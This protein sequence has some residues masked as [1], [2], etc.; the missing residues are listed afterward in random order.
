MKIKDAAEAFLSRRR[1]G[2]SGVSRESA[3]HGSN[4]VYRRLRERGYEAFAVNPNAEKVEGDRCYHDLA[5]IPGG[6]DAVQQPIHLQV[7]LQPIPD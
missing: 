5:S 6:V 1:I 4:V 3:D 2:V 7:D